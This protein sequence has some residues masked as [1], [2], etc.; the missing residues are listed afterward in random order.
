M[1][2]NI[3]ENK[4]LDN[5]LKEI[6][7]KFG[8]ET[9]N[10]IDNFNVETIESGSYVLNSALGINGFPRGR[11]IEIY[12]NESSGKT[13]IALQ[14]IKACLNNNGNVAYIDAE[15]AL[16]AKYIENIGID[17]NK[18]LVANPEYGEQAFSIVDALIKTNMIDLI[19]VDSVAALTPKSEIEGDVNDQTMG[20]HARLMSKGLRM[21]QSTIAKSKTSVIFINQVRE[22]VG[23][24]FGNNEVTTGGRALK[25]FSSIRLEVKRSELLK[26]GTEIVGIKSK[27]IVTKNK[28]APPF[29]TCFIDIFFGKGFDSK[30]EIIDF[31]IEYEIIDKNGSWYFI[32]GKK[33]CQGKNQLE[34]YFDSNIEEFE[35]IKKRVL[36]KI[37][38][39]KI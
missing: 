38:A 16:D 15:N 8:K 17:P 6:E 36:D 1:I 12:G 4:I 39:K 29:K 27:I 10:K 37:E 32:D 22:K 11:I 34:A 33:I 35:N 28:L 31:A 18:L 26:N 19:V 21:I 5:A 30:K 3:N 7:K 14:A 9:F 23:V 25:F 20:S 13:T 24:L 2:N